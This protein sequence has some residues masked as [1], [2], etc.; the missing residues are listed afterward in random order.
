MVCVRSDQVLLLPA[1][2]APRGAP[3]AVGASEAAAFAMLL[4]NPRTP[5]HD[6]V[7]PHHDDDAHRRDG[8]AGPSTIGGPVRRAGALDGSND[9][10]SALLVL[11]VQHA[12]DDPLGGALG[13]SHH[14]RNREGRHQA[15]DLEGGPH[16]VDPHAVLGARHLRRELAAQFPHR[17]HGE[18]IAAV[19]P[20]CVAV[21]APAHLRPV[22]PGQRELLPVPVQGVAAPQRVLHAEPPGTCAADVRGRY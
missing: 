5:R 18:P 1:R 10:H 2:P 4:P 8:L 21:L 13:R 12:S 17:P 14:S 16:M 22:A 20:L 19:S 9:H 15:H 6:L 3:P 7:Q 11:H